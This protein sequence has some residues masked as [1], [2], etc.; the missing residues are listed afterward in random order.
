M[1]NLPR[2]V[3]HSKSGSVPLLPGHHHHESHRGFQYSPQPPPGHGYVSRPAPPPSPPVEDNT[4]CSLPSISTLLVYADG[5]QP[6]T[7]G[8][9]FIPLFASY[10][11]SFPTFFFLVANTCAGSIQHQQQQQ[12]QQQQPSRVN[13][14][15]TPPMRPDSVFEG[16]SSAA[17]DCSPTMS[18]TSPSST[19]YYPL[20]TATSPT[21]G[22]GGNRNSYPPAHKTIYP[23]P[24]ETPHH[25]AYYA[26]DSY[27]KQFMSQAAPP[28]P[29]PP[30]SS[31]NPWHHH[32]HQSPVSH[33]AFPQ[34]QDRYICPTCNKAFSR[35]SSLRIHSHSHT[36]EK[37]FK[38]PHHGCGKAFSV[39]SNM[40]RHERGCHQ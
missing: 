29:P 18:A 12:Q 16:G 34:S 10:T 20:A 7:N 30:P 19:Y 15:P 9:F 26:A 2:I 23:S 31:S 13:L 33:S 25:P 27:T 14:P 6:P 37:P 40:K 21:Y 28:P 4:K 22:A 1:M 3:H 32:H 39:R 38:C 17:G 36:G 11:F 5:P 8:L 24:T 35:P